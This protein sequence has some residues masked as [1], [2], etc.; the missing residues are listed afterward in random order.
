MTLLDTLAD[1]LT[2]CYQMPVPVRRITR[3]SHIGELA[4]AETARPATVVT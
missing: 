3:P 4:F 2:D 1:Y